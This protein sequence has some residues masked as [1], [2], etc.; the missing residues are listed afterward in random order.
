MSGDFLLYITHYLSWSDQRTLAS[1]TREFHSVVCPCRV[2]GAV[3]IA[4]CDFIFGYCGSYIAALM[5]KTKVSC[6]AEHLSTFM[7][8]H[9]PIMIHSK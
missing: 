5:S 7:V 1:I 3:S 9:G 8:S 4:L 6:T 2:L